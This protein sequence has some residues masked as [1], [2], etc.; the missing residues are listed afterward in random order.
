MHKREPIQVSAEEFEDNTELEQAKEQLRDAI[1][2]QEQPQRDKV[3]TSTSGD[4][5]DSGKK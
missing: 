2:D 4:D 1:K 5:D 3:S